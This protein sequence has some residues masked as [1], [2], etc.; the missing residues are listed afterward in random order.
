M[1]AHLGSQIAKIQDIQQSLR[2]LAHYYTQMRHL[3]VPLHTIDLGGGLA[4]DYQGTRSR[5]Y[6]SMNY[7]FKEYAA[8][9]V[10]ILRE[11]CNQAKVPEPNLITE[12]GRAMVAHHAV[13]VAKVVYSQKPFENQMDRIILQN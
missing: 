1:H 9:I 11:S 3:G 7:S 8:N 2:E 4:V 12:S 6:C 10:L 5:D 13:L